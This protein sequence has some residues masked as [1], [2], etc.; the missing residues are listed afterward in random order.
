MNRPESI[1]LVD[2]S[3]VWK[4]RWVTTTDPMQVVELTLRDLDRLRHGVAHL[5]L[6]RDAPPYKRADVFPQY[7]AQR[8]AQ[9]P[10]ERA[11]KKRLFAELERR[12]WP[13][14]FCDG[15]EADD[16]IATL[17]SEYGVWCDDVRIVTSDKDAAQCITPNVIQYIPPAGDDDWVKRDA[18]GVE[19]KWGVRPHLM[20]FFQALCGDKS[21]N[22]P[23]VP[24]VGEVRAK[25]LCNKY[26]TL[27]GLA[28]GMAENP[29]ELGPATL[30]S[31]G[32]NWDK[33]KLSLE[34]VT[35]V[36]NLPLD[37]EGLLHRRE[38]KPEQPLRNDM[39][40]SEAVF[41]RNDTP[42]P[43]ADNDVK[44]HPGIDDAR[45]AWQ[46]AQQQ[47]AARS[48]ESEPHYE[49]EREKN[50]EH[51]AEV[52][53]PKPAP[54]NW[55]KQ[56]ERMAQRAPA[57]TALVEVPQYTQSKYGIVTADL[58]PVDL[59]AAYTMS[60]WLC[61]GGLY[62]AFETPAQIFS[63]MMRAK[64]LGIGV[65]TALSGFFLIEGK[66][67]ASAD[68]IRALAER[69]P[70]FEYLMPVEMSATR[71]TWEGKHKRQPRP[72]P[73]TYTVEEARQAGL[74]TA[75]N[76]GKGGNWVK[77]PQDMLNKTAASKLARILWP[78]ATIGL[79]CPEEFGTTAEE[80]EARQAA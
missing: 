72:V 35:M 29:G 59:T 21:D 73:F 33:L 61:K 65:T 48:E 67:V 70:N 12:G 10:E 43:P 25:E 1:A 51:V 50:E 52:L 9:T 47:R 66:P 2:L 49:E 78:A 11:Q 38:P 15:Y 4:K 3:Y 37:A 6:C 8:P 39:D 69:D 75:G 41:T 13:M 58:Q 71:C 45:R 22:I 79:Y 40:I 55:A 32:A 5:I 76:Y 19:A 68:L 46:E 27:E 56:P 62:K 42:M 53:P 31:L 77:R 44:P 60:E 14:A 64:E 54:T 7:K 34:L 23:G 28:R 17:A 57:T 74:V 18:D 20:P 24:G 63:V 16:V 80:L 26:K 36:T 30:R